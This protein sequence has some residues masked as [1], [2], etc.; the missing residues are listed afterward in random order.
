MTTDRNANPDRPYDAANDADAGLVAQARAG[1]QGAITEIMESFQRRVFGI[2]YRMVS[3]YDDA[4]D[5]TQEALI[6]V[7]TNLD[8]FDGRAAF[9]TWVV[10]IAM[11]VSLSHL[12][13]EKRRRA[14]FQGAKR[15]DLGA[16]GRNLAFPGGN[17]AEDGQ[18]REPRESSS[19]EQREE[20]E[21]LN[22]CLTRISDEYRALLILRDIQGLEYRQIAEVL[23]IPIG[24]VKSRIFR[25]RLAFRKAFEQY[26]LDSE[27]GNHTMGSNHSIRVDQGDEIKDSEV[28]LDDEV[29]SGEANPVVSQ[30]M[31]ED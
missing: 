27:R 4:A 12:R 21:Q 7:L 26:E 22:V 31:P 18:M 1:D 2:C 9:S 23:A 30:V 17:G 29:K 3:H 19:V 11:N 8:R 20:T 28:E 24:T 25:A 5:L 14:T 16:T 13:K 10:R 15:G 6:K